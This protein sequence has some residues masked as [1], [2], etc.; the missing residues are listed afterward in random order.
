MD[1]AIAPMAANAFSRM[2]NDADPATD[3]QNEPRAENGSEDRGDT[4]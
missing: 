4:D 3:S 1:S 2:A